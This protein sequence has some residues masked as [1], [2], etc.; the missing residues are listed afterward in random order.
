MFWKCLGRLHKYALLLL[1]FEYWICCDFVHSFYSNISWLPYNSK[2]GDLGKHPDSVNLL[3]CATMLIA[4]RDVLL[5]S[6]PAHSHPMMAILVTTAHFVRSRDPFSRFC[7]FTGGV[8]MIA[9]FQYHLCH[10]SFK[11][12]PSADKPHDKGYPFARKCRI[13]LNGGHKYTET[14]GITEWMPRIKNLG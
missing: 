7:I 14:P 9:D 10:K 4:L 13:K 2:E 8:P 1:P 12:F 6:K 3:K 11:G 5:L